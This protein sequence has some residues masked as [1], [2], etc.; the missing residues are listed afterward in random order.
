MSEPVAVVVDVLDAEEVGCSCETAAVADLVR[1]PDSLTGAAVNVVG[2]VV[3]ACAASAV[4]NPDWED[5]ADW[6]RADGRMT[7]RV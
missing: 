2:V 3:I 5:K 7:G 6:E 1:G 4:T